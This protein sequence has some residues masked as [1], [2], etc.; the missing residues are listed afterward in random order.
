VSSP[1]HSD[2]PYTMQSTSYHLLCRQSRASPHYKKVNL[3]IDCTQVASLEDPELDFSSDSN[4]TH[5]SSESPRR[6]SLP[7]HRGLPSTMQ[8]TNHLLCRQSRT[9]PHRKKV[10]LGIDCTQIASLEGSKLEFPSDSNGTHVSYKGAWFV[11]VDKA[12]DT[13]IA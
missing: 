10:N 3:G 4:G 6:V 8:S 1:S 7:S 11:T 5:V 12:D 2:L 9:A 13:S